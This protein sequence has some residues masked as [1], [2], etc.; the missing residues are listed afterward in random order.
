MKTE[1]FI[2]ILLQCRFVHHKIQTICPGLEP[3]LSRWETGN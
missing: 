1:V 3:G 2:E